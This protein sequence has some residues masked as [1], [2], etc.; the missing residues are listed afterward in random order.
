MN[1]P[2]P[3][4]GPESPSALDAQALA[5]LRELD[6]DGRHGVFERVM[7]TYESSLLRLTGQ[8]AEARDKGDL[9]AAGAVA[10]TL[11]SSSASIGAIKL[12]QQCAE[13]ETMIRLEKS[14][15]LDARVDAMCAEVEIVLQA[16]RSLMDPKS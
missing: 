12:S 5:R 6:P 15:D 3:S 14:E 4:P 11:K 1:P 8:L 13:I 9:A 16:L 2:P 10:H 7:R